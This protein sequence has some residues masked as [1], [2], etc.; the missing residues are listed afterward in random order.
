MKTRDAGGYP[1]L[2]YQHLL[3]FYVVARDGGLTAASKRLKLSHPTLSKQIRQLESVLGQ[4]LFSREG[5]NLKLTA[6]GHAAYTYAH[7]IFSLGEDFVKTFGGEE[8]TDGYRRRLTVGVTPVMPKLIVRQLLHPLLAAK[9]NVR[10]VVVEDEHERLLARIALH[11]LDLVLA[12]APVTPGSPIRAFNHPL[13]HSSLTFFAG[14]ELNLDPDEFPSCLDGSPF[15]LP[16]AGSAVRRVLEPWFR[17]QGVTPFIAVEVEDLSLVKAMGQANV[18]VFVAP[19][20]VEDDVCSV[21][22][23][24]IL[25]RTDAVREHFYAITMNR[26][27]RHPA[28]AQV[29]DA[30]RSLLMK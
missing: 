6:A 17:A 25:G 14:P 11:E 9:D 27:I 10:L 12:D 5:R 24:G 19:T 26:Q 16:T 2:N 22:G 29:R 8:S 21:Y 15:I 28:V 13:G 4:Q 18:G 1:W 23:V 7:E 20:L 30:A 3:Y